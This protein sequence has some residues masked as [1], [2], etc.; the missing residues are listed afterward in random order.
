M[1]FSGILHTIVPVFC[2]VLFLEIL[3]QKQTSIDKIKNLYTHP[4]HNTQHIHSAQVKGS[5]LSPDR[6]IAKE[7]KSCTYCC[8]VRSSTLTVRVGGASALYPNSCN[9]LACTVRTSRQRSCNQRVCCPL[10][11]MVWI[12][13]LQN[14][15]FNKGKVR[16]LVPCCGQDGYRPQVPQH[17]QRFIQIHTHITQLESFF[18]NSGQFVLYL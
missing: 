3:H 13:D 14:G 2:F 15:F 9:L 4:L 10:C 5:M 18:F 17:P 12:Y 1:F 8:Y 16:G 11:S 6:V 7:V